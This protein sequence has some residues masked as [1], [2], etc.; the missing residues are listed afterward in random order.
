MK[1]LT[2]AQRQTRLA[3]M[4]TMRAIIDPITNRP[5]SYAKIGKRFGVSRARVYQILKQELK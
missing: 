4:Q 3:K 2:Y 1:N 5:V